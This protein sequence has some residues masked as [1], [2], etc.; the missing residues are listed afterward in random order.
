MRDIIFM[1]GVT[2]GGTDE[3]K[4][5]AL[6]QDQEQYLDEIL[7]STTGY[8]PTVIIRGRTP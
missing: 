4:L 3:V 2:A 7:L 6:T 1:G 5:P 8:D